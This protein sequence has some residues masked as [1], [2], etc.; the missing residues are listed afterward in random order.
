MTSLQQY[1]TGI[2]LYQRRQSAYRKI[3]K[4]IVKAYGE[5]T[6]KSWMF[7]RDQNLGDESPSWALRYAENLIEIKN[8]VDAARGFVSR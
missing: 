8:V 4:M 7:G 3:K 6:F 2:D 5:Q 1:S